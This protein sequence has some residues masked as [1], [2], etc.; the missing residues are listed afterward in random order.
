M[1]GRLR[2]AGMSGLLKSGRAI[3]RR[4]AKVTPPGHVLLVVLSDGEQFTTLTNH[5]ELPREA[6]AGLARAAADT[7]E[8]NP[9]TLE[10]GW[11]GDEPP[12]GTVPQ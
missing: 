10:P 4:A 5:A 3:M 1:Q 6:L 9:I 11:T 7:L 12:P 8:K 2:G